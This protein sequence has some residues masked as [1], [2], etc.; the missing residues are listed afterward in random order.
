MEENK[1][2]HVPH[3][4]LYKSSTNKVLTG[5]CGGM[6]EYINMDPVVLRLLWILLVI[7]TGVFPGLFIYIIA[8]FVI[9]EKKA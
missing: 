9:P 3:K 5:V 7:V 4:K 8:A 2:E 1:Q 6:A